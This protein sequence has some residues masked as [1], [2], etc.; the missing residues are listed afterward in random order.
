MKT[1]PRAVPSWSGLSVRALPLLPSAVL[2]T[3]G[4]VL[5]LAP[6]DGHYGLLVA[7]VPFLAAAVHGAVATAL[8]GSL[9]VALFVAL[10]LWHGED[11]PDVAAIKLAF[12]AAAA[13][14]AVLIGQV[15]T[16]ERALNR[17]RDIAL[18]LQQGLLPGK[19]PSNSAV[20]VCHRYA[21]TDAEAGVGGDWFDMIR[22][23]SARVAL[24]IGDVVGHGVAAAATMGR[25]RTA[26]RTLADLDLAPDEL[27]ARMDD[28]CVQ[29]SDEDDMR[30]LGATCLYVVYDPIS[31]CCSLTSAG[32]TPPVLLHTD[33]RAEL[34][35][36]TEHPP[37]GVGGTPFDATELVL[38]E[39]T[40]IALYTDGLLDLRHRPADA[41]LAD[42]VD[43]LTP[44]GRPLQ[45]MCDD[46][47]ERAPAEPD[48]DV[49][50]LL[51]RVGTLRADRVATWQFPKDPESVGRAR[52]VSVGQMEL[53]G[54]CEEA[55]STEL[56]ISELI[57]NAVRYASEPIT[58]RLINDD[59]AL[60][61]EVSDGSS[62][63][64]HMRLPRLM[65][66]GGRGLFIIGRLAHRWGTRY[67]DRGKTVWVEQTPS[68]A[69]L[70]Q[71]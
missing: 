46:V 12:V 25:L 10:H 53:W 13:A 41:A 49:A 36:L 52:A 9:T 62:T 14:S 58:L 22:L 38:D 40:V 47:Y 8:I 60:I 34:P 39:G 37:L 26:V 59:H 63:S 51:A 11:D 50:V 19:F 67:D 27:M 4:V 33:G 15:R 69:P 28:L 17:A 45:E 20:E 71:R 23:S 21:P 31:R 54:L 30:D 18:T 6:P 70:P 2:V 7:V 48:D 57:T 68:K 56:V 65:D 61:C 32:H 64:P 44:T 5:L 1:A 29:L 66:E 24:V 3:V 42:V 55:F 43:A 16:R 35:Q